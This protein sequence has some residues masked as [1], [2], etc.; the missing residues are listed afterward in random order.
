[1]LAPTIELSPKSLDYLNRRELKQNEISD[2]QDLLNKAQNEAVQLQRSSKE[3]LSQMTKD[4]LSLLQ[5]A[6]SLAHDIKVS[7]LSE[8]G[9]TN[10]LRQP[11]HSNRVDLNNDGIV[12]VGIGRNMVFPPVNAPTHIKT[13]WDKATADMSESAV[14][15][16]QLTM[17]LTVFGIQIEGQNKAENMSP[18][19]QW[20]RTGIDALFSELRAGLDFRVQREGWTEHNSMLNNFYNRFEQA[21]S[22]QA[23]Q[24]AAL[25]TT[26]NKSSETS[27]ESS[28]TPSKSGTKTP[29]TEQQ[30]SQRLLDLMQSIIDARLGLDREKL[31]EIEAQMQEVA[32]NDKLDNKQK[33]HL[34]EQLEKLKEAF[35][36][37]LEEKL[38]EDEKRKSIVNS[39]STLL[40]SLTE[41]L[42]KN[43][44][45]KQT[46]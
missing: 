29:L 42:L 36:A 4:E 25:S 2:F 28:S 44:L 5:K 34:I 32:N 8:E 3:I 37:S 18:Q 41:D 40:N 30:K 20:S 38:V 7:E 33:K 22:G 9:A 16:L 46:R 27:A 12:E 13:A 24:A 26:N 17:H 6:N 14:M 11:D 10:L 15:H 21:L 43:E 31:K 35:F 19:Q 39:P 23:P 45:V 1:M